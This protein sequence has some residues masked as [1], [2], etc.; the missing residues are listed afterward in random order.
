MHT[1]KDTLLTSEI[2]DLNTGYL[3]VKLSPQFMGAFPVEQVQ[4]VIVVGLES[5]T[6]IPNMPSCVLGLMNWHSRI[7]WL[8]DLPKMLG[9]ELYHGKQKMYNVVV[10][11][12]EQG[13]FGLVVPELKGTT[14]LFTENLDS[15]HG[16]V[17]SHLSPYI[18]GYC[19]Q[20][21]ENFL[22]FDVA[23]MMQSPILHQR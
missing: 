7:I 23:A 15:H 21:E 11:N 14:R 4:E 3:K 16:K 8:V 10:I 2:R 5:L 12:C 18:R 20:A 13:V 6:I 19:Q 17:D 22:I 1:S 9:L